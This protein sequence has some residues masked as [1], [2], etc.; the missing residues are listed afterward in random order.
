[1]CALKRKSLRVMVVVKAHNVY[2]GTFLLGM[3]SLLLLVMRLHSAPHNTLCQPAQSPLLNYSY[4]S[5]ESQLLHSEAARLKQHTLSIKTKLGHL[6][7]QKTSGTY[8]SFLLMLHFNCSCPSGFQPSWSW[9]GTCT[10]P[11]NI[12][13]MFSSYDVI[14][15][16]YPERSPACKIVTILRHPVDRVYSE[17][18][19][20]LGQWDCWGQFNKSMVNLSNTWSWEQFILHPDFKGHNRQVK[21][22][23]N[24]W[25]IPGDATDR[26]RDILQQ[27]QHNLLECAY[28]GLAEEP[29]LSYRLFLHT[30]GQGAQKPSE[31]TFANLGSESVN[32]VSFHRLELAVALNSLD[33]EFY[34]FAQKL[35][36]QRV[37]EMKA[38]P[39]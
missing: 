2:W 26:R 37:N 36:W 9:H 19:Y 5:Y 20:C 16:T 39:L 25:D 33:M 34:H 12:S 21:M 6:H 11:L 1:L 8:F 7:I 35:F 27:A 17:Y 4:D 10:C 24:V 3:V 28:F 15:Q 14:H 32:T 18:R 30:F 31:S 29:E 23:T 22:F 13:T 38:K